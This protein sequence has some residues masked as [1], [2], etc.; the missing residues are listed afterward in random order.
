M[1]DQI[2]EE[3]LREYNLDPLVI[4]AVLLLTKKKG[5]TYYWYMQL[6][7]DNPIACLVKKADLDHNSKLSR[8]VL[9]EDIE[10]LRSRHL[11]Y[12]NSY[13]FL[14]GGDSSLIS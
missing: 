3:Q 12:L 11:K 6:I 5:Q 9:A 8:L 10:K 2:S 4:E 7:K 1:E 13:V 14:C